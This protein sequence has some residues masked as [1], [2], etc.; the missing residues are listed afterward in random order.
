MSDGV[1]WKSGTR[2]NVARVKQ[3]AEWQ[4][5]YGK[6]GNPR[7][8]VGM[9]ARRLARRSDRIGSR[10]DGGKGRCRKWAETVG[11]QGGT[12]RRDGEEQ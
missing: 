3:C 1:D 10:D 12:M 9:S 6:L 2:V 5:T 7:G 11:N 4:G 8:A